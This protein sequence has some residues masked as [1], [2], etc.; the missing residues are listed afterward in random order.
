MSLQKQIVSIPIKGVDTNVDVMAAEPGTLEVAENVWFQRTARGGAQLIKRYGG[1]S[2]LKVGATAGD[3]SITAGTKLATFDDER[4]LLASDTLNA[5]SPQFTG[6][7]PK[8]KIS[9]VGL[10]LEHISEVAALGQFTAGTGY[11]APDVAVSGNLMAVAWVDTSNVHAAYVTIYDRTT[12]VKLFTDTLIESGLTTA[13]WVRVVALASVFM[14]VFAKG[15]T[16]Q[17]TVATI[18][19]SNL[20]FSGGTTVI[21][22]DLN[23]S[24]KGDVIRN[25]T[26]D[27]VLIAY[28]TTTPNLKVLV[29]NSN[30][31]AG[32]NSTN[33]DVPGQAIG[34]LHWDYSD[35]NAYLGYVGAVVGLKHL[36]VLTGAT[37]TIS[38]VTVA[39]A[40][41]TAA[42]QVTGQF[43]GT[44]KVLYIEVRAATTYNCVVKSWSSQFGGAVTTYVR[45]VGIGARVFKVST[46]YYLPFT[47]ESPLQSTYF[48]ANVDGTATRPP[49]VARAL[50]GLGGGLSV[51]AN[52]GGCAVLADGVTALI[53]VMRLSA[54]LGSSSLFGAAIAR[55]DYSGAGMSSPRRIGDNLHIPGGVVRA[56]AGDG[57]ATNF[58][59]ELGFF[60]FPETPTCAQAANPGSLTLLGTYQYC[61]VYSFVD[62]KGQLHRSAP[63]A[64]ASVT[65]TGANQTISIIV[66]TL[67]LSAK[68]GIFGT[69]GG[70]LTVEVYGT[71]NA[72]TIF[73]RLA[74]QVINDPTA[75]VAGTVLDSASD[76]TKGT[77]EI[78]YTTGGVLP[79]ISPPAAKLMES[80][81]NRL[82][83]A[84]TENPTELWVSNEY[85]AGQGVSFSDALVIAM[86]SDGGPITALAE[87]DDRLLIFKRSAIY[88]LAGNGPSLTG[89][90]QFDQPIRVSSAVGA[91]SQ[92]GVV[93]MRDGVMFVSPRGIYMYTRGG[94]TLFV[95]AAVDFYTS[96]VT[97]TG[98]CVMENEE[99]VRFVS[100]GAGGT[101]TLVYHYGFPDEQGIG[102]WTVFTAQAAVDC[103]VWNGKFARL[104]SDGTV[105]EETV[106]AYSDPGGATIAVYVR[107]A[108]LQLAQFFARFKL[109]RA[110]LHGAITGSFN[111][112]HTLLYDY[113]STTVETETNAVTST[114]SNPITINPARRRCT[115]LMLVLEETSTAQGFSL[116]ALGLE[117]GLE[118]GGQKPAGDKFL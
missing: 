20:A 50:Y 1:A 116:S 13:G 99:Q 34:W 2:L 97:I 51:T 77:A 9:G 70:N 19:L 81:H 83:L 88:A 44:F 106:G 52:V 59:G 109:Y 8:G 49:F 27:S 79:H 39:D 115:S 41:A 38:A 23:A 118:P 21:V 117:V 63:S 94:Q 105:T 92:A 75:D 60:L 37:P 86:E 22:S 78:L 65:L 90:G 85:R 43:T 5:Y 12:G 98:A 68:L 6:W 103:I 14:L 16:N 96:V 80:W 102:R 35:G 47:Y 93:K 61:A 30:K 46:K 32:A 84:G 114:K 3:P 101:I 17:I 112:T 108:W 54:K 53:P 73:Y 48:V 24:C 107:F 76:T 7:S 113:S 31:T 72:G 28:H 42:G 25:G 100:S 29:I 104:A 26:N 66:P 62:N 56:Y 58:L 87:M 111:L 11:A 74:T 71:Q 55:L 67:R 69:S 57:A 10:T 82:F 89:D 64:V 91:I 33:A 15:S 40:A 36:T 110:F 4:L 18:A 45:S 95:G